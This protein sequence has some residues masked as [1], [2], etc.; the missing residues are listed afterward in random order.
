MIAYIKNVGSA[1]LD[2]GG[3]R[4]TGAGRRIDSRSSSQANHGATCFRLLKGHLQRHAMCL[5]HFRK[6]LFQNLVRHILFRCRHPSRSRKKNIEQERRPRAQVLIVT[7]NIQKWNSPGLPA[8]PWK[9][10][11]RRHLR[12]TFPTHRSKDDVGLSKLPQISTGRQPEGFQKEKVGGTP[13]T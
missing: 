1:R 3:R 4:P 9:V 13:Q 7:P 2:L 8:L 11:F 12:P 6:V 10:G 5:N